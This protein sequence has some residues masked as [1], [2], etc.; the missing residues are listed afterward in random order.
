MAATP[1][2]CP[3]QEEMTLQMRYTHTADTDFVSKFY[4]LGH[5][6]FTHQPF[7]CKLSKGFVLYI[8]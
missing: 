4:A 2:I 1:K 3:L 6:L 5:F 8:V 7:C